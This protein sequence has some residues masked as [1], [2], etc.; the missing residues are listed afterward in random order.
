VA[1]NTLYPGK[2]DFPASLKLIGNRQTIASIQAMEDPKSIQ[3][4]WEPALERWS[5]L[6]QEFLLYP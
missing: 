1:L 5:Q 6:R 2:I 4:S 3:R